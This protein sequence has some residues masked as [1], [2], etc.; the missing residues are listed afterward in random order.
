M[1][2]GPNAIDQL[3][4]K[5]ARHPEAVFTRAQNSISIRPPG[6]TGFMVDLYIESDCYT[7]SFDRGWHEDF[8]TEQ[9]ALNCI[10][11]ALSSSCRLA[12]TYRG[13]TPCKWAVQ[14]RD[15]GEWTTDSV[16]GLLIFP[17]WRRPRVVMK[18]NDLVDPLS[19]P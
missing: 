17:F 8:K 10:A 3:V 14:S 19:V 5:L 6:D 12:V 4:G 9:E 7:V 11:F 15:G 13:S 1:T 16:T 18:Q 2:S